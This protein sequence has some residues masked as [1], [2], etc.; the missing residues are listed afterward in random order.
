MKPSLPHDSVP[1][2]EK[3]EPEVIPETKEPVVPEVKEPEV[4][5]YITVKAAPLSEKD[6]CFARIQ[7]I[8]KQHDYI[9]SNIGV[10]HEYWDLLNK[11]RLFE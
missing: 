1:S 6:A 3:K 8:L 9:E 5:P 7:E 4:K 2:D 10:T 11:Y